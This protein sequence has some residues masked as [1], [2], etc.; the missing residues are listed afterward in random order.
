MNKHIKNII[1]IKYLCNTIRSKNYDDILKLYPHL[2]NLK[3][4]RVTNINIFSSYLKKLCITNNGYGTSTVIY[5]DLLPN[6]E[7]LHLNNVTEITDKSFGSFSKIKELKLSKC[8]NITDLGIAQ[9]HYLEALTIRC[10]CNITNIGIQCMKKLKKLE[11]TH[12]ICWDGECS[13]FSDDAIKDLYNLEILIIDGSQFTDNVFTK[14]VNLKTLDIESVN[15][16]DS[17]I[18]KLQ[19]LKYLDIHTKNLKSINIEGL[20]RL[21]MNIMHIVTLNNVKNLVSLGI[22]CPAFV[23]DINIMLSCQRNITKL[24]LVFC[25]FITGYELQLFK[26]LKILKIRHNKS[27]RNDDIKCL[28]NLEEIWL[29]YTKITY[30]ELIELPKLKYVFCKDWICNKIMKFDGIVKE[31]KKYIINRK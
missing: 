27:I 22:T 16:T 10:Y 15:I 14:L 4:R 17:A 12:D 11:L 28:G 2:K 9:L 30:D 29:Y 31:Y 25:D 8:T 24:S 26:K 13:T 1:R 3:L 20:K 21:N 18:N 5:L 19:K 23:G 6:L 7:I